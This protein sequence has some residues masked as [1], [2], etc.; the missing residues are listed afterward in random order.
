MTTRISRSYLHSCLKVPIDPCNNCPAPIY[1]RPKM[2]LGRLTMTPLCGTAKTA[3]TAEF[4]HVDSA[5]VNSGIRSLAK[6]Y[7]SIPSKTF[8][9]S[10]PKYLLI[11]LFNCFP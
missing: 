1:N 3:K 7:D 6:L 5:L 10:I 2:Y 9:S 8:E 4:E 11:Y